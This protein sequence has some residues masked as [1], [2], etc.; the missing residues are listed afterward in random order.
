MSD[1]VMNQPSPA[2]GQETSRDRLV[3]LAIAL[4]RLGVSSQQVQQILSTTSPDQ[5]EQQLI[6][7]P[8]RK[9]RKKA[10]LI[11]AAIRDGYEKPANFEE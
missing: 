7:F 1:S 3:R 4:Q 10:S 11:V 6:W 9:A 8:A 5:I 2:T